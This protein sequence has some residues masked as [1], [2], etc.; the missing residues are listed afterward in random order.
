M[1]KRGIM[2]ILSGFAGTGKGTIVKEVLD[3]YDNYAISV[4]ATTRQPRPGEVDGVNYF[5]ISEE[6]FEEMIENDEFL[7]HAS[8][9]NNHY[10]TPRPYVEKCL[11]HG[12]NVILE[13]EIQG[14]L[15]IKEKYP[16][17]VMIFVLPPSANELK[18][19][20]IGRGTEDKQ[21]IELRL[22]RAIEESEYID[23]YQYVLINDNLEKCVEE[24]DEIIRSEQKRI[25][26]NK[27]FISD[28]KEQLNTKDFLKGE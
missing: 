3:K 9:V 11:S 28:I 1:S 22:K 21:T 2:V 4:S 10:G 25:Q 13:I 24:F 16:E 20:L 6:K 19:R 26:N 14:A 27:E 5:F 15:K 18:S 12:K 17:T 23:K 7:E 8:Y